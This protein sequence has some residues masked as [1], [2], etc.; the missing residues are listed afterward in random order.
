[1][2]LLRKQQPQRSPVACSRCGS[3]TVS[4]DGKDLNPLCLICRA[5]I[6]ARS[7]EAR[8][9]AGQLPPPKSEPAV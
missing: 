6:L 5:F 8:R 9:L 2:A 7:F 1:M 3:E 4:S